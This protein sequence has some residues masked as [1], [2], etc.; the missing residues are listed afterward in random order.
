MEGRG[1][2]PSAPAWCV[3]VAALRISWPA[4]RRPSGK[5]YRVRVIFFLNLCH[6]FLRF[7]DGRLK[8]TTRLHQ[9]LFPF[10]ENCSRN[11]HNAS[12]GF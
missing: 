6:C 2:L 11:C 8:R 12:R 7:F 10:G 4:K 9:I 5:V 3:Y 1:V